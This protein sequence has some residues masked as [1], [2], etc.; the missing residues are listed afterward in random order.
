MASIPLSPAGWPVIRVAV[1][2]AV[3]VGAVAAAG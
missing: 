2:G 1:V 3:V